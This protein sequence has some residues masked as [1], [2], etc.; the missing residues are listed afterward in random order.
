[1]AIFACSSGENPC[2]VGEKWARRV[3]TLLLARSISLFIESDIVE[4]TYVTN[5]ADTTDITKT[6]PH[7]A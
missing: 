7:R 1:L 2:P 4:E 5:D 3:T 6:L